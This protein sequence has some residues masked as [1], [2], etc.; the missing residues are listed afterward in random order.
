MVASY[1][2]KIKQPQR[3]T[4]PC[5]EEFMSLSF[6]TVSP[7]DDI[8]HAIG[9][10]LKHKISGAMVVDQ[11]NKLVGIVSEKD[12]LLLATHATYDHN[13][14]PE[15]KVASIMTRQVVSLPPDA[16]MNQVAQMFI[17]N[18]FRKIPILDNFGH[19]LGVVRRHDVL[20]AIQDYFMS[21][22]AF[23]SNQKE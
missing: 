1:Q 19:L 16:G 21:S 22:M 14:L 6:I 4:P 9:L 18:H 17:Q 23:I 5:V 8:Y 11:H 2:A 7:E 20:K 3:Q 12:C 13:S 10:L 15:G